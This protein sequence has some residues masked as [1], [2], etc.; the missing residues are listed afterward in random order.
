[1]TAKRSLILTYHSL[2]ET[3]SV[4]SVTPAIFRAHMESL[5]RRKIPVVPL[6]EIR[7]TSGAVALTF[8]D[9][10]ANF[11]E[12]ALPLLSEYGFPATVFVVSGY[13]GGQNNWPSQPSGAVPT[14]ALMSWSQLR[15][16]QAAGIALG[17]HSVNHPRLNELAEGEV[18]AELEGCRAAIEDR[19][20]CRV[21][22]FAY[23]Y[24]AWNGAVRRCAGRFFQTAC[25][26]EME[27]VE[28]TSDPLA[29]PRIDA[30][31][32]RSSFWFDALFTSKGW[33]YLDLRSRLRAIR[34]RRLAGPISRP[35]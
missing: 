13:C 32:L 33:T 23:P 31:Y 30:Y 26:T 12:H 3:G 7:R 17:A 21:D 14:L 22:S 27:A 5:F 2:D 25:T 4:I 24:G 34:H 28:P 18:E 35:A 19:A 9:A 6:T 1:M 15:E 10:F 11:H 20:G 8:D 16:L 29:L